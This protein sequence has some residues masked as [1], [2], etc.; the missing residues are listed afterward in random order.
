MSTSQPSTMPA[1]GIARGG[2]LPST[3]ARPGSAS[4]NRETVAQPQ[5]R[6]RLGRLMPV[7]VRTAIPC[8]VDLEV[9]YTSPVLHRGVRI[10]RQNSLPKSRSV[11]H[12]LTRCNSPRP[13]SR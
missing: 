4:A 6:Q 5:G 9:K 3:S 7:S 2:S 11:C 10:P 8:P 1:L 12:A 13:D